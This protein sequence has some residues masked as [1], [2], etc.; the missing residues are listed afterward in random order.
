MLGLKGNYRKTITIAGVE[1]PTDDPR[2]KVFAAV[3]T[4]GNYCVFRELGSA[5]DYVVPAN[6]TLKGI[7]MK[8]W[9]RNGTGSGC[10]VGYGNA[11]ATWGGGAA[12]A[13][14]ICSVGGAASA[15]PN[16]PIAA[17]P[18]ALSYVEYPLIGWSVPTGK[19]P[20]IFEDG[21]AIVSAIIYAI[22]V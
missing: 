21:G 22:E 15:A 14:P 12:P 18:A 5:V 19:Y 16:F 8:M 11:A 7:G 1:Y 13:V 10:G 17:A 2:L 6:K 20:F 4:G 3:T 9:E